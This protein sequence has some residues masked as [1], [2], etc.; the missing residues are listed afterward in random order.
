L[1]FLHLYYGVTTV[2]WFRVDTCNITISSCI[3]TIGGINKNDSMH[4]LIVY[5]IYYYSYEL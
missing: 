5:C 3:D 1:N 2:A 4:F